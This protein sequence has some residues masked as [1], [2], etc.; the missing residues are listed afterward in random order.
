MSCGGEPCW[1]Y[2]AFILECRAAIQA[3]WVQSLGGEMKLREEAASAVRFA[4]RT[5]EVRWTDA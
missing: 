4:L 3:A 1:A 5:R 2:V